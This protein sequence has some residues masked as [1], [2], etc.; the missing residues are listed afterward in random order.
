[1][2][3]PADKAVLRL[4]F[5]LALAVLIA[6]GMA[7]PLPYLVCVLAVLV[8]SKPGPPIPLLKVGVI[9]VLLAALVTLGVLMDPL[10]VSYSLSGVMLTGVVLYGLFYFGIRTRNPLSMVLVVTFTLIPIAGVAEQGLVRLI[11]LSLAVGIGVGSLVG[12]VSHALFP[13]APRTAAGSAAPPAVSRETAAWIALRG[14]VVVLP[15]FVLA[16]TDPSSYLAAIMKSVALGQQAGATDT[17]SAGRELV[18][19]TLVAA[20]AGILIWFG[21]SLWPNLWM[22][23]LWT[24]AAALWAGARM[25]GIKAT[26]FPPSFWS[27]V[28]LTLLVLL[29]PAIQDSAGGKDVLQASAV[30]IGLFVGIAFYA[31][32]VVWVLET[33][34]ASRVDALFFDRGGREGR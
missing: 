23:M 17:R 10:L 8:L 4:A 25:Y 14:M 12:V 5:G 22:L 19:S 33:W 13:D 2:I 9:A 20:G 24:A 7:L 1:M 16:L 32:G 28:L 6:Y 34:R 26:A 11:S 3:A 15:V 31:W 21:L 30:R 29:G 18:G 27:N